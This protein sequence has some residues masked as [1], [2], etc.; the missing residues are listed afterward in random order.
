MHV[1]AFPV[2]SNFVNW[3]FVR[4]CFKS[5]VLHHFEANKIN[6]SEGTKKVEYAYNFWKCADAVY[7][8]LSKS[9]HAWWNYSLP[10]LVRLLRHNVAT[11]TCWL[12]HIV[13]WTPQC[14][15]KRR[16][17]CLKWPTRMLNSCWA[18]LSDCITSYTLS[19]H[20]RVVRWWSYWTQ[21]TR[22]HCT[23]VSQRYCIVCAAI[24]TDVRYWLFD[25]NISISSPNYLCDPYIHLLM[26]IWYVWICS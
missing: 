18:L 9:V 1:A 4:G 22:W 6:K 11:K 14:K 26:Y 23:V 21:A 19:L 10:K 13:E 24:A 15:R 3:H 12:L 20:Y 25:C 16:P 7:P 8:T 17:L 2:T 5:P